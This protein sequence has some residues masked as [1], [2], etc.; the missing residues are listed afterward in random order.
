M[1]MQYALIFVI[2]HSFIYHFIMN[3][4]ILPKITCKRTHHKL[5]YKHR[6]RKRFQYRYRKRY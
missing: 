5:Y 4:P 2:M 3:M 1:Q 6:H